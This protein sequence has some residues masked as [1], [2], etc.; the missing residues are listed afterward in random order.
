MTEITIHTGTQGD[1]FMIHI[2]WFDHNNVQHQNDIEIAIMDQD[3]PRVLAIVLDGM[4]LAN[5]YCSGGRV[6]VIRA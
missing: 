6:K 5:L 3:K 4:L 2:D 1:R